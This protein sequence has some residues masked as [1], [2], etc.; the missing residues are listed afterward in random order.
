MSFQI[1]MSQSG[2][3][4]Y[5]VTIYDQSYLNSSVVFNVHYYIKSLYD[6]YIEIST[7]QECPG[8][9]F[10]LPGKFKVNQG[11]DYNN[12]LPPS[13]SLIYR[14]GTRMNGGTCLR[15]RPLRFENNV[16]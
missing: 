15:I 13:I 1:A 11:V 2:K 10:L 12:L 4:R 8:T 9:N 16:V 14:R 3:S 7:S 5:Y 6:Y